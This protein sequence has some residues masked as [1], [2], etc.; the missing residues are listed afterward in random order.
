MSCGSISGA[1]RRRPC[2]H[3]V[4][5]GEPAF[6]FHWL[7]PLIMSKHQPGTIYLG[8]NVIFKL[9]DR[10]EHWQVISPD[11]STKDLARMQA[12]GSG[13]ETYGV[14]YTIA[15]SPV[16][17]GVLWAGTDDGKLWR[18]VDD[19]GHWS[20]L[21]ATSPKPAQGHLVSRIE[22]SHTDANVA[23]VAW[24]GQHD[25]NYSPLVYRTADGG[26]TWQSVA[27][28]I[29]ATEPVLLV[30]EDPDNGNVLYAGTQ[31]GL[32]LSLDRGRSWS[33][34]GEL[35]TVAV[36][37]ILV[38]PTTHSL[39]IATQGRSLY[40]MD[41]IRPVTQLT[42][43]V[44]S[45]PIHLFAP[46]TAVESEPLPSYSDW[47]GSGQYRG[48]NPPAGVPLT[49]YLKAV[50]GDTVA[51]AI[52]TK[53]GRPVAHLSGPAM[54]GLNRVYWDLKPTKD[55]LAT[56]QGG[57]GSKYEHPGSYVATI[58]FGKA[59]SSAN[60]EVKAVPGLETL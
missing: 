21:T 17:S 41:R 47:T 48:S 31:H 38:E 42:R 6:R 4:N 19:G 51:I 3:Q 59:K 60:I 40:V 23:Y 15:E 18:T 22:A 11:L 9:T 44:M 10:A 16:K 50:T 20:D 30:R 32:W 36:A 27:G 13:A 28:N 12:V 53:D 33:A 55:L 43:E 2:A 29:P 37:D 39:V 56:Y 7:S 25:G 1:A 24:D 8:G 46:D 34:F 5:E 14:V 57:E 52:T 45:E 49:Y 58:T 54:A 35:P 26:T